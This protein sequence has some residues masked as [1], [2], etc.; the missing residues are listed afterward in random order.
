MLETILIFHGIINTSEGSVLIEL[1]IKAKH[2]LTRGVGIA[3][4][5]T[6]ICLIRVGE[7]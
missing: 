2:W 7:R 4:T 5:M 1:F 6:N 3:T